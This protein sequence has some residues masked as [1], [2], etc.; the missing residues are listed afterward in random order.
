MC[1]ISTQCSMFEN[2]IVRKIQ[3]FFLNTSNNTIHPI[4]FLE[5]TDF[6]THLNTMSQ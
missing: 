2:I 3:S 1:R 6:N 5:P 4:F